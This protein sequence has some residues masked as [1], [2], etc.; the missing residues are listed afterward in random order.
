LDLE[1][2]EQFNNS[3]VQKKEKKSLK[4]VPPLT[5]GQHRGLGTSL[6]KLPLHCFCCTFSTDPVIP[7]T[8]HQPFHTDTPIG[9]EKKKNLVRDRSTA[10]IS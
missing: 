5:K 2:I 3:K 4:N 10:I 7:Q 6:G 8:N 9:F 1:Y